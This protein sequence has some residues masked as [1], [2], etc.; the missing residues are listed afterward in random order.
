MDDPL[1]RVFGN[2]QLSSDAEAFLGATNRR[3]LQR[4]IIRRVYDSTDGKI[5]L[6][7]QSNTDLTMIMQQILMQDANIYLDIKSL[8]ELVVQK[9]ASII[10][11][12]VSEYL[13]YV[14]DISTR[15]RAGDNRVMPHASSTRSN[16]QLPG[17]D[18]QF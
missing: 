9:C 2:V 7:E 12:N 17:R 8:N 5:R 18:N 14:K 15:A 11:G 10:L 6:G 1:S 3:R 4:A 13:L 16:N